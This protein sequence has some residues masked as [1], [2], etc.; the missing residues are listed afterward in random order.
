MKPTVLILW[1][2]LLPNILLSQEIK[3]ENVVGTYQRC[4]M[5]CLIIKIRPDY[6]FSYQAED[7]VGDPPQVEGKWSFNARNILLAN[8]FKQPDQYPITN[9][10]DSTLEG[11][12]VVVLNEQGD[13]IEWAEVRLSTPEGILWQRTDKQGVAHFP[14]SNPNSFSVRAPWANSTNSDALFNLKG[15]DG[16][17]FEVKIE[18]LP[19]Y[20]TDEKWFVENGKL[21]FINSYSIEKIE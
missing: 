13:P 20:I 1:L 14:K 11:V 3:I 18:F 4:L 19:F 5:G 16:N 6:T 10:K 17:I 2:L 12:N 7:D 9:K 15:K 8:T 21:Y